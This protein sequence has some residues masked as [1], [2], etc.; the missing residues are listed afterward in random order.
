MSSVCRFEPA[1]IAAEVA[2]T[3]G[4]DAM[5][6]T[7]TEPLVASAPPKLTPSLSSAKISRPTGFCAPL[8]AGCRLLAAP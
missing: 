8:H 3:P 1:S 7:S 5:M 2:R 6:V 4:A